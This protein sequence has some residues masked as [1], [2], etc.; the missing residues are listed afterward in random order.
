MGGHA[1]LTSLI[2]AQLTN[3]ISAAMCGMG[4]KEMDP[5]ALLPLDAFV[6]GRYAPD[7]EIDAAIEGLED[8][9]GI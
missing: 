7:D 3:T 8:L 1:E 2:A 5:D 4:G 9:V 6:A